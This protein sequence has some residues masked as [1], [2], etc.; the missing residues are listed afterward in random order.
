M[1]IYPSANEIKNFLAY[2]SSEKSFSQHTIRAYNIDLSQF[3]EFLIDRKNQ[4]DILKVKRDDIRDFIGY[5]LK[6]GYDKR[7]VARKLSSLK[8]FFRYLNRKK[9]ISTNPARTIKTPKITKSL[10]GFLTQY[11]IQKVLSFS[12]DDEVTLRNKAIVEVLYGAGLR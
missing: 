11:Q 10:P 6:Y 1:P 5:L 12:G 9:I 4:Q 2:L 8:S 3:L 7:S